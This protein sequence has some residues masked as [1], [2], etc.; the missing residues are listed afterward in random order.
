MPLGAFRLNSLGKFTVTAA[1]EVIRSKKSIQAVGN[2]QIDTA[3]SK[4]GGASLLLDGVGDYLLVTNH[5]TLAHGSENFTIEMWV[6]FT[7]QPIAGSYRV[8]Y[9]ARPASTN[10]AYPVLTQKGTAIVYYANSADRIT[11]GALTTG[12]WYHV[13]VSRSGTDTKMF[14]DGTQVGSTYTDSTTY[15]SSN[16]YIGGDSFS[17]TSQYAGWI[18]ELRIS[19]IARYTANFTAPTAP[20]TND[21]NTVLLLHM[22]GTDAITYFED[23]NGIRAPKSIIAQGTA[24]ISTTQ[25][26]FGGS[27]LVTGSANL[28]G[29]FVPSTGLTDLADW[30]SYTGFTAE[31][32]VRYVNLTSPDDGG[33]PATLGIMERN[34]FP[35]TWSMGADRNGAVGFHYRNT[36]NSYISIK[37]ANS[38]VVA[39]TWYH[40]AAVK[41]GSTVKVYL[42]G[43]ER[44]SATISGTP[45]AD[46]RPLSIGSYY[47]IGANAFIDEIRISNTARYT[48]GFTPSTTPFVNDTN[49]LFLSHMDGTNSSTVLRDDNGDGRRPASIISQ[50]G[51]AISTAQSKF[52][53]SSALFDGTNDY[54]NVA[55]NG[56]L[57]LSADYTIECWLRMP[58]IPPTPSNNGIWNCADHLFYIARYNPGSGAI[59][60][61]DL[62][63]GGY[64]RVSSGAV[65]MNTNQWYHVAISRSGS[66]S[67]IFLDGTQVG[68]TATWNNTLTSASLNEIAKYSSGYWN[69]YIDE[70]RIS[71]TARYTGNFTPSTTPFQNDANTLL[72]IHADGTNGSTVFIDDNG[73]K[74]S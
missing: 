27:S 18:D 36:A 24:T 40:I 45:S 65:A 69:V 61:I 33:F 2:A 49:T 34:D 29:A 47:R 14:I 9:D 30:N 62:F 63:N 7:S 12:V 38:L 17:N 22:D 4:F 66:N 74:P 15:L 67:R 55:D 60:E 42:N 56:A 23:D 72:L 73:K 32:W 13:A 8:F 59:Y 68:S 70:F 58:V 37:S 11:S 28:N 71:N 48:A 50:N 26:Q 46:L 35:L 19:K 53:G 52:G 43:V 57:S 39:N 5:S 41:N 44:A 25:S 3:Q 6:R 51:A 10:G 31:C 20:F 21:E 1:A 16:L 54:L 64:N